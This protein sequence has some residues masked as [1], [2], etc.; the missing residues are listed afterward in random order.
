MQWTLLLG[1]KVGGHSNESNAK[2]RRYNIK[3]KETTATCF[4]SCPMV[5]PHILFRLRHEHTT[6][7][8][9][10]SLGRGGQWERKV[11]SL[12]ATYTDCL[13]R[14][15]QALRNDPAQSSYCVSP[16]WLLAFPPLPFSFPLNGLPQYDEKIVF[17]HLKD[18]WILL[19]AI[20]SAHRQKSKGALSPSKGLL[21][22]AQGFK[23]SYGDNAAT[24]N[25]N[26]LL[27]LQSSD[28]WCLWV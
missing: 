7:G 16:A 20:P 8:P 12:L 13:W 24:E 2:K 17:S 11:G 9:R 14:V 10:K 26:F 6:N 27:Q 3:T 28:E 18:S 19:T 5:H 15:S 23:S 1:P 22:G 4:Y 25:H 21:A